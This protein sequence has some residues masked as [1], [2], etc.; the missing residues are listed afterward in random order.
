M[1]AT[2]T[3]G[4]A[5]R[6]G[7]LWGARPADWAVNE[8][9]QLPTYEE[10]I[11]R[12]GL[13]AGQRVLEVGC[14]TGVFLRA[15]ADRGAEVVGLDASEALLELARARVP[16][17]DLRLGD[18]QFLPFEDDSFDVVAGFNSFFFAAD[19][20]ASLREA[21]R[22]AKPGA[23]VVVQVWG[24]PERCDLDAM[25]PV[26]RPLLPPPPPGAPPAPALWQAGVLEGLATEAGLQ[27]QSAYDVS[28]A[29]EY[30]DEEAIGRAMIS[31]GGLSVLVGER[32]AEVRRA[33]VDA[34]AAYRQPDGSYRLEN[35][36]H[37]L[38][39]SA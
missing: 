29:Y 23:Q 7:P 24:R 12:V 8:E 18:M 19:L 6:W 36:W 5:G 11:R 14:G 28:W 13:G 26:T 4:S 20:V 32:E 35:E 16:E 9:Q 10:A 15:A 25:K 39:A 38:I 21:G 30:A 33:I 22:V 17:A 37:T 3:A 27:P 34:L 31:A 1:A 2:A